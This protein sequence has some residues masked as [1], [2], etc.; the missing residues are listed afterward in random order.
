MEADVFPH[1]RIDL[2]TQARTGER[3]TNVDEIR[4]V[5]STGTPI[6][7]HSGRYAKAK[8]YD[9]N[10]IWNGKF[11]QQKRVEVV[12]VVRNGEVTTVTAYVFFG[13]WS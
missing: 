11:Y 8:I 2:H 5:V 3:G 12:Y 9:F 13:K 1:I 7:A 6:A 4:D 10:A